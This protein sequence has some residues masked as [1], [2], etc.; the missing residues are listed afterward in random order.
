LRD[1]IPTYISS[2]ADLNEAEQDNIVRGQA[3]AF[4]R[5]R[6]TLTEK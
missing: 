4:G 2:R 5:R 6:E 3:W 1:L